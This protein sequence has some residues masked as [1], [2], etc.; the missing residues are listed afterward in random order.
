MHS[1]E[2]DELRGPWPDGPGSV[3]VQPTTKSKETP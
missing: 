1:V 3:E 2:L